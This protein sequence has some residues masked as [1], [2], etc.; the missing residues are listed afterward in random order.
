[1]DIGLYWNHHECKS[2]QSAPQR[3]PTRLVFVG[4]TRGLAV[5]ICQADSLL[6]DTRYVTLRHYWGK[7]HFLTLTSKNNADLQNNV[8]FADLPAT[9]QDA[10][11]FAR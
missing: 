2:E 1:M 6:C 4:S 10:I 3:L 8:V 7:A 9:F 11:T 5:R